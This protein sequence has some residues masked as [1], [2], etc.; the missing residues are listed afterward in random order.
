MTADRDRLGVPSGSDVGLE[1]GAATDTAE[2]RDREDPL[3]GDF[4]GQSLGAAA[5]DDFRRTDDPD[6]VDDLTPGTE[7]APTESVVVEEVIVVDEAGNADLSSGRPTDTMQIDDT[8]GDDAPGTGRRGAIGDEPLGG[9][10][11]QPTETMQIDDTEGDDAPGTGR[12]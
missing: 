8:E 11:G 1:A 2:E 9:G 4:R 6:L 3:S 5:A 10:S 12:V 7:P